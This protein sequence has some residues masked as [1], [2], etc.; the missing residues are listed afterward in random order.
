M[1][2]RVSNEWRNIRGETLMDVRIKRLLVLVGVVIFVAGLN[3]LVPDY[4]WQITLIV[5]SI[6]FIYVVIKKWKS[7]LVFGGMLNLSL[8]HI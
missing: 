6:L 8:I 7:W 3:W 1:E 2:K 5:Y 4:W